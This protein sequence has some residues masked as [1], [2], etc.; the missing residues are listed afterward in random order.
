MILSGVCVVAIFTSLVLNIS[1]GPLNSIAGYVFVPMQAG[2]NNA[3]SWLS[4]RANDFKT[5]GEVLAENKELKLAVRLSLHAP[6]ELLFFDQDLSN[7][8]TLVTVAAAMSGAKQI[9]TRLNKYLA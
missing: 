1:G 9:N 3:G 7:A 5:L 4:S 8:R 6:L 2:I